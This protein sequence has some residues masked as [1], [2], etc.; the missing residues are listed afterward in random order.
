MGMQ[1]LQYT[2]DQIII[3]PQ[4][5][6]LTVFMISKAYLQEHIMLLQMMVVGVQVSPLLLLLTHQMHSH[7]A[8]ML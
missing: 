7:M 8:D 1:V 5:Q 2:M 6:H 3:L 4:H